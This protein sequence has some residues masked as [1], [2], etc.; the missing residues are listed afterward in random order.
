M[1]EPTGPNRTIQDHMRPYEV[2]QSHK[3]PNGTIPDFAGHRGPYG[4]KEA[5]GDHT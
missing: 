5:K 3:G 1:W 2:L 4:A